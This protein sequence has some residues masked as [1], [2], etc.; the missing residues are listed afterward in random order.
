[1]IRE[2]IVMRWKDEILA[3]VAGGLLLSFAFPPWPARY[4]ALVAL[5]P[6]FRYFLLFTLDGR[7]R[8]VRQAAV[9]GFV[10]GLAFF[11]SLL[12]WIANLIPASSARIPWLMAPAVLLLCLYLAL[13]TALFGAAMGWSVRRFGRGALAAAP[14]VW[15]I[16]ELIRSRGELGFSWGMLS[17]A[18]AA[19]PVA[20][21]GLA[22]YGPFGLSMLIVLANLLFAL[23]FFGG[24]APRRLLAGAA[25]VLLVA[26]HA[27]WGAGEIS[28]LDR[29]RLA[30][31]SAERAVAV[32]QPNLDLAIKWQPAFR[33]SIFD[34]I[35]R[36]ARS[37]GALGVDLV[38]FPETAAPAAI[39]HAPRLMRRL[40]IA[41]RGAGTDM[42]IG[43]VTRSREG[44]EWRSRNSAGLFDRDGQLVAQYDK[45]NLLPF[46]ERIPWSQYLPFLGSLDFGQANFL[47][48]K[49][50]T[51]FQSAAGRFG[52]MI[53]FEST[54][55]SFAREY[56]RD[57]ADFLVNITNDGWFGSARGPMQHAETAILRAIENRVMV[58]R[59]ANTG[60]SMVIDPTGRV[61]MSLGLGEKGILRAA[62]W[63]PSRRPPYSRYGH[64]VTLAMVLVDLAASVL[65]VVW[66]RAKSIEP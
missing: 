24:S 12:Y 21:Q 49:E 28:R 40:R 11:L 29:E 36:L 44:D 47:P 5:A 4:L 48:G 10:F 54:F 35:D 14:A 58:L 34:D 1:M 23:V 18:M 41:A 46:G 2:S 31:A 56:V 43:F 15:A 55:S 61:T 33:D 9:T 60:V 22:L 59:A 16:L 27:W 19:F 25:L 45:V 26:G 38:L 17:S 62:V 7:N 20:V 32:V 57:G 42:L 66:S 6:L 13:Y 30:N 50:A 63:T 51:L 39:S 65:V 64:L 52:V 37:G 53:C 8:P 3:G